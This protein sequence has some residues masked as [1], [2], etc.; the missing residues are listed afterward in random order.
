MKWALISVVNDEEVLNGCLLRSPEIESANEIIL[1]RGFASAAAAYNAAIEKAA[2]DLLVLAHQDVYLPEGWL[3]VTKRALVDLAVTDPDWAVLG[4]WGIQRSGEG[5][6]FLYCGAA[7]RVLGGPF[8]GGVAVDTL[9]EVLLILR[10]SSGLRF[11]ERLS[12]FHLYGSDICLEARRRRRKCYAIGAFCVHNTNQYWM[13]PWA[14][15]M[16][17]LFIRRKWRAELPI[18]TSC[19]EIARSCW[20]IVRWNIARAVNL[21]TGRDKP[22]VKRVAD[23]RQLCCETDLPRTGTLLLGAEGTGDAR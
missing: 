6:G 16:N 4:A 15:W 1:Q 2:A 12:G 14:F 20:P 7:R 9:D 21:A 5:V 11:D 8:E 3:R 19:T 18:R 23:P 10:K 22:P 13:L 17:Y